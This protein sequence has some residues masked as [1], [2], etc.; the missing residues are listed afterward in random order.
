MY[1]TTLSP[2]LKKLGHKSKDTGLRAPGKP[3]RRSQ[4]LDTPKIRGK[5][6]D[7]LRMQNRIVATLVI[8]HDVTGGSRMTD[9][10]QEV[11]GARIIEPD[12]TRSGSGNNAHHKL[13]VIVRGGRVQK[14]RT[15]SYVRT[16][17][18]HIRSIR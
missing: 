3:A 11:L 18:R 8:H 7:H 12:N 4:L 9:Q 5:T 14:R 2:H 16:W 10:R 13:F 6:G 15:V 17:R 1:N